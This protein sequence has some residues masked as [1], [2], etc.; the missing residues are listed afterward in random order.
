MTPVRAGSHV[1]I[2]TLSADQLSALDG[3]IGRFPHN[4]YRHYRILS[5]RRQANVLRAMVQQPVDAGAG[6]AFM[7]VENDPA[8]PPA[9]CVLRTLPWET[10]FF[11]VNMARLESMLGSDAAPGALRGLLD[12]AVEEA[13]GTGIE[14]LAARVDIADCKVVHMLEDLGFRLMDTLVTYI[15]GHK[16]KTPKDVRNMGLL[17]PYEPED[18]QQLLEIAAEAYAG[19]SGRYHNDPHIADERA[20]AMY[21]E[22]ARRCVDGEWAERVLVTENGQ[23]HLH[24][25]RHLPAHRTAVERGRRRCTRRWTRRVPAQPPRRLHGSAAG[26]SP[27]D[28]RP[29]CGY[30]VSDAELQLPDDPSV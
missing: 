10:E 13:R 23:G 3:L 1:R 12:A 27:T 26:G 19:F 29:G 2:D 20:T 22:W 5:R 15:Y 11:G 18:R 9:A 28:P 4:P 6:T 14:H 7:A 24:G 8:D 21:V 30:R 17:R 25:L 16:E